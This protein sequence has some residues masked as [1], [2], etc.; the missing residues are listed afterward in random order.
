MKN[1]FSSFF[2][3]LLALIVFLAGSLALA[4]L[5]IVA[6]A[7]TGEKPVEVHKGSYL[8]LDFTGSVQDA[9]EQMEG[10]DELM[11][12][13]G[14]GRAP[15]RMQLRSLVRA[16]QAAAKDDDI[17]GLYLTGSFMPHGYGS[18]Y[19]AL[20]EVREA[21]EAFKASGKP[22]RAY[23]Q[24]LMTT[25]DYYVASAAGEVVVDPY[26]GLMLTGLA[27]QPMFLAGAFEKLGIGV[28]VTR[29]GK[30]KSAVEPYTRKEMSP[31]NRAQTQKLLDD[32]WGELVAGIEKA[33]G[34]EPGELQKIIDRDGIVRAGDALKSKLIDRVAYYDE[35]QAELKK[36][37][38]VTGNKSFKQIPVK[39]Y[40]R[41]VSGT[42]AEPRRA[43]SG[44][45][46]L[47]GGKGRVAIVYAE[48]PIIDGDGNDEGVVWGE[49][50]AREIRKL[51]QDDAV[52]AIV[53][54]INSPGGSASASEQVL[55]EL[56]LAKE[57]KPVI[58]SMGTVAA[59]GGYW[60]STAAD[61]VYAEPTTITGSIGVFGMFLNFQQL[62]ND[63][64]GV[65]FDTVKTG[66][67]ADA[68]SPVRP[69]TEDELAMFQR[70]VD[71]IY[72]EFLGRVGDARKLSREQVHEI[73]QGRVWSG[74]E[75]VKLGLVDEVGGLGV[76]MQFA[77]EKAGLGAGYGVSEYPRKKMLA[78]AITEALAGH[79]REANT[80]AAGPVTGLVTQFREQWETLGQFNDRRGVYA[81][82]PF[83]LTLP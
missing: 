64:L 81:R 25:R 71:W 14:G 72:D 54:R 74:A 68:L 36:A 63:K 41:L 76:A 44:G 60:I 5:L 18:G 80:L 26:G 1:F 52:K 22:V 57:A 9:P 27:S 46:E 49:G 69:K 19:A 61:R 83:D 16:I 13:F 50:Y 47:G 29:V 65:T 70:L 12:A 17:A 2:A 39:A 33:R 15:K 6:I 43:G 37:T 11:E 66:R 38:D 56:R 53:V 78:E 8:V 55:R 42:G 30:Y 48:G 51:R 82:L 24:G 20:K 31:E 40:A 45:L 67:F 35:V 75:A 7:A 62:T 32:V 59:S 79:R 21:V 77:A 34:L 10:I 23:F 58:I 4:F 28:Q 3:S 73:A